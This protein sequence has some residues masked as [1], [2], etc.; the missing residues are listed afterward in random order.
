MVF[1]FLLTRLPYLA[2]ENRDSYQENDLKAV[3]IHEHGSIEKLR[4]EEVD[5]PNLRSRTDAVVKLKAAALNQIKTWNG[6]R[7]TESGI[8]TPQPLARDYSSAMNC[9]SCD[10]D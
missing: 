6:R 7:R 8:K 10:K 3:R 1:Y 2:N 9:H 5:N 4:Y